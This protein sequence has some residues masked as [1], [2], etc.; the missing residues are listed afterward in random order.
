VLTDPLSGLRFGGDGP[1]RIARYDALLRNP[2]AAA[3]LRPD[4]VLR[5]GAAPVSKTLVEW[6]AGVPAL[7][8]DHAGRWA[9]PTHDAVA[10]LEADPRDFCWWLAG[11][12]L[13]EPD[14]GWMAAWEA[15]AG[16]VAALAADHLTYSPWCEAH[17]IC[18]LV[19]V[20]PAGEGLF[21]A[22]S[23]P[24][25]QLDTWSGTR[26]APLAVFGNRG[27]S[28]IDG[29]ASTLAGINAAGVPTLGLL[30]DL[31]LAHDL[32]GLLL[33]GRLQRPLVVLN[34][35]GG[36]I[37]DYLPQHGLPGFEHL[38]RTPLDL[39]IADLARPFRLTHRP[40]TD[41]LGFRQ[42]LA[43]ALVASGPQ[44]IE[45]MID[46]EASRAVHLGFWKRVAQADL[47][48]G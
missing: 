14:S 9:D 35:G 24:I 45:V 5:L 19:S 2:A 38:W 29:Q 31:S 20:L 36:R 18:D 25:R 12:G 3:A 43:E 41:G 44:L 28:G 22:N 40:V 48:P 30:G 6:L 37:F 8:L 11:A 47:L 42:V 15:G 7:L 32:S 10:H 34:N 17:L 33:A 46:A 16:Q 26:F 13:V 4:W 39:D 27:A 1:G 23:L 21:C